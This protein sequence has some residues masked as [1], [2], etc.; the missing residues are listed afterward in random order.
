[1]GGARALSSSGMRSRWYHPPLLHLPGGGRE[2]RATWLELFYDL[3]FVAAFIQLGNGL[4]RHVSIDGFAVF[5]A[6][7]IALWVVWSGFTFY[8]NRF[9]VDDFAH[10]VLVFLQ[11]SAV[12]SMAVGGVSVM[13]GEY[14]AF[15]IS[16]GL[17][18]TVVAVMTAERA[19]GEQ[20]CNN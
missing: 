1:M 8:Q 15:S 19:W 20:P 7:M 13:E 12:A 18:L 6:A 2:K 4:G 11:M 16:T 5:V 10:R 3:I 9:T 14:R 17:A